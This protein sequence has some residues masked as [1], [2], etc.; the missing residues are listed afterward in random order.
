MSVLH[1]RGVTDLGKLAQIAYGL[2]LRDVHFGG[3][4]NAG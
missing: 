3:A 1:R 2:L 4:A